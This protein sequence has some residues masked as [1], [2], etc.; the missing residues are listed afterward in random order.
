MNKRIAFAV[1]A[2]MLLA[3]GAARAQETPGVGEVKDSTGVRVIPLKIQ[4][5]FS[6]Y[7]GDRKITSLPYTLNQ[8]AEQPGPKEGTRTSLRMGIRVPILSGGKKVEGVE[9]TVQYQN[10]GTDIDCR[11]KALPAGVYQL[12][13]DLRRSSVYT[14]TPDAKQADWK[15]SDVISGQPFFREFS[16]AVDLLLKDG[17]T[18]QTTMA[19]D[20]VTGRVLRV[21]VTLTL[22]PNAPPPPP[23][24]APRE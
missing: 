19:T 8:N 12:R 20:P 3:A 6:E 2:L 24:P 16:G 22:A 9:P 14:A 11:V 13:L 15:P 4:V 1:A 17:Q 18:G 21:D 7:E 23:P 5:V 10:V